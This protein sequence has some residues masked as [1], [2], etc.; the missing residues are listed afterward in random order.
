MPIGSVSAAAK[1]AGRLDESCSAGRMSTASFHSCVV[2]LNAVQGLNASMK[3]K[4]GC[5]M[6]STISS[7]S[8]LERKLAPC[9][10]YEQ[11][12]AIAVASTFIGS[13]RLPN[14]VDGDFWSCSEVG[15]TWPLVRP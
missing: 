6:P 8:S 11:S 12:A 5:R 15:D 9:A 14:G 3:L 2:L 7:V 4:P 10:T 13:S 1:A